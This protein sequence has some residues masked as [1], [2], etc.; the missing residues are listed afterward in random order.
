MVFVGEE[1]GEEGADPGVDVVA[2]ASGLGNSREMS[3]PIS[4][5]AATTAGLIVSAG[6]EPAERTTTLPAA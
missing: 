2:D 1:F 5:M 6:A 3:M 4:A